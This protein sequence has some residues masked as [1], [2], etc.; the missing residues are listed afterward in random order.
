M[1]NKNEND[2]LNDWRDF[3]V[4]GDTSVSTAADL[5]KSY[6]VY[7]ERFKSLP[8]SE[9]VKRGWISSKEDTSSLV[10]YFRDIHAEQGSALYRKANT[11]NT[12]LISLWLSKVKSQAEMEIILRPVPRFE[13]ISREK[14][15]EI[16]QLSVDVNVLTELPRILSEIGIVLVYIRALPSMKLDGAVFKV[17]SEKPV[18]GLSLRY[19]RL[20]YFWFTLLHELSHLHLHMDILDTPILEDFDLESNSEIEVSANRLAKSTFVERRVWR[21]CEPKYNKSFDA[22]DKFAD[23]IG[24]HRSI[25]A[26][27]LR[28]EFGNYASYSKIVNEYDVREIIFNGS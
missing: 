14:L 18:I 23:Q 7:K 8:K 16:A 20:D 25:I 26:G 28:K 1:S 11:A 12:S 22:I 27:M 6:K 10:S 13:G 5:Y 4:I 17:A 15:R 21:N 19:S 3:S 24:I 9:L 2:T